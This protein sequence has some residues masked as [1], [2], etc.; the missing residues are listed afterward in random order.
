M[1]S[2]LV[3]FAQ[4]VANHSRSHRWDPNV[5]EWVKK[6]D[7]EIA[8][9]KE[10]KEAKKKAEKEEKERVEAEK[11]KQKEGEGQEEKKEDPKD[12]GKKAKKRTLPEEEGVEKR[13]VELEKETSG[14]AHLRRKRDMF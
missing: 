14:L 6:S 1:K 9:E 12:E 11:K 4:S 13:Y 8:K 2:P 3:V 10:E 7:E 5:K